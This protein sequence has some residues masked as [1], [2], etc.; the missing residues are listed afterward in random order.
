MSHSFCNNQWDGW[1]HNWISFWWSGRMSIVVRRK[2][3][4]SFSQVNQSINQL[5][6]VFFSHIAGRKTTPVDRMCLADRTLWVTDLNVRRPKADENDQQDLQK[7]VSHEHERYWQLKACVHMCACTFDRRFIW[8][9]KE[10][11]RG[12]RNVFSNAVSRNTEY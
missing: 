4:L 11:R 12:L 10:T 1:S 5:H 2:S 3:P 7:L 9:V 8:R 6:V